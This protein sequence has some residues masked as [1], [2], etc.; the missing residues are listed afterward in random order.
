MPDE[1]K[2]GKK[3]GRLRGRTGGL[4]AHQKR[5]EAGLER[6]SEMLEGLVRSQE[7]KPTS[8]QIITVAEELQRIRKV[9]ETRL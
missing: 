1:T 6:I 4:K 9:L 3:G 5:L 7:Q 8:S 2:S